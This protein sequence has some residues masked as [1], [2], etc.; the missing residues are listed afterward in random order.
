MPAL[1]NPKFVQQ[2]TKLPWTSW[3]PSVSSASGPLTHTLI[4][5]EYLKVGKILFYSYAISVLANGSGSIIITTPSGLTPA[6]D[7]AGMGREYAVTGRSM[8]CVALTTGQI[9]AS[10]SDNA[11]PAVNGYGIL[12]NGFYKVA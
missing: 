5:A 11:S 1:T 4:S 12:V 9:F 6:G 3:T 8:S 10:L 7:S 2:L